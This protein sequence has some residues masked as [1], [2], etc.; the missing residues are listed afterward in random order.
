MIDDKDLPGYLEEIIRVAELAG[1]EILHVY[2]SGE[3]ETTFKED[4]SPLTKADHAAHHC[5]RE[6]LLKLTPDCPFLSE[7]SEEVPYA[8]RSQ[9]SQYWLVDPLDGTKEF[10][11]QNGE[12]T[13]NI[14]LISGQNPVLGVVHAPVFQKTFAAARATG[15]RLIDAEGTRGIRSADFRREELTVVASR[16]HS[17]EKTRLFL[18]RIGAR[19]TLSIGSSL[20]ICLVAEGKAHLYPRLGPTMEWDTA[21]AHCVL[22]ESGGSLSCIEG[23]PLLYNRPDMRNPHF[24]ACGCPAFP[25]EEHAGLL[26]D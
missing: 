14:A 22:N 16:S 20:K 2:H 17:T 5:I 25:W 1:R 23:E 11:K 12:F 26:R 7:E 24:I 9:W 3:F 21:A 18:D 6:H 4:H 19:H 8:V 15:A 13:V 10:V